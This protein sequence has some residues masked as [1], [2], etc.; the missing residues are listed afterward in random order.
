[1]RFLFL[2]FIVMPIVEI[3]VL[4][5]VGQIIGTW[6]T[7][8]LVLLS[9]FIGVN[10]LRYQGLTTLSRAQQRLNAGEVPAREMVEGIVLAVGGALLVTP[11]FVTDVIGFCCLVPQIRQLVASTLIKRF[12]V[13]AMHHQHHSAFEDP[14]FQPGQ[15]PDARHGDVIDGEYRREDD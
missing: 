4:I 13:V 12:T 2:L 3:T 11:G 6:Y 8:G 10:M 15:R 1:M 7:V 9:A 14:D 5:K